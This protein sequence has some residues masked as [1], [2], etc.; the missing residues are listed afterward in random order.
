MPGP[1]NTNVPSGSQVPTSAAGEAPDAAKTTTTEPTGGG[2]GAPP[3]PADTTEQAKGAKEYAAGKKA[4]HA[5]EASARGLTGTP[6]KDQQI[7]TLSAQAKKAGLEDAQI[8]KLTDR[9]K[10]LDQASFKSE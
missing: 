9:L 3:A 8:T 2:P 1:I 4:D 7:R 5:I 6:S 10:T